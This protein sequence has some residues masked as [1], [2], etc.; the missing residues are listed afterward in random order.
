MGNNN[1]I[2]LVAKM[3]NRDRWDDLRQYLPKKGEEVVDLQSLL[4]RC[5][6]IGQEPLLDS[7]RTVMAKEITNMNIPK[8]ESSSKRDPKIVIKQEDKA[9]IQAD[10]NRDVLNL[11]SDMK[12]RATSMSVVVKKDI[13]TL[14]LTKRMQNDN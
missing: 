5:E 14:K 1:R 12:D 10:L 7:L 8:K 6:G 13:D 3:L 4:H 9:D 2:D 11:A